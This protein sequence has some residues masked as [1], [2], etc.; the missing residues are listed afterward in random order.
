[1]VAQR[2]AAI[3]PKTATIAGALRIKSF[4]DDLAKDCQGK[5]VPIIGHLVTRWGLEHWINSVPL[6]KMETAAVR[7]R[8]EYQLHHRAS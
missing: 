6:D 2:P 5:M 4:L 3:Q 8:R 1:M 7:G